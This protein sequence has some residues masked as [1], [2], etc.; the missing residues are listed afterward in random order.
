[1]HVGPKFA[2]VEREGTYPDHCQQNADGAK[3]GFGWCLAHRLLRD[4][5]GIDS[6]IQGGEG[7]IPMSW[8]SGLHE[9]GSGRGTVWDVD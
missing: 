5:H 7:S 1:M 9:R 6:R 2:A 3:S 4:V 8:L